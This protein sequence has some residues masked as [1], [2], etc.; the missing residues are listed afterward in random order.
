MPCPAPTRSRIFF[1]S[2]APRPIGRVSRRCSCSRSRHP[3]KRTI[4]VARVFW[5]LSGPIWARNSAS[6]FSGGCSTLSGVFLRSDFPRLLGLLRNILIGMIKEGAILHRPIRRRHAGGGGDGNYFR[7]VFLSPFVA[8]CRHRNGRR[9]FQSLFGS[10]WPQSGKLASARRPICRPPPR[11]QSLTT[12]D[13]GGAVAR[14]ARGSR[15]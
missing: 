2:A 12:P 9:G 7:A 1:A 10:L 11:F 13:T 3:P 8:F 4:S 15:G 6:R 5:G 14:S